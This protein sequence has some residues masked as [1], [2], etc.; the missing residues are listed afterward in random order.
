MKNLAILMLIYLIPKFSILSPLNV[1]NLFMIEQRW[2]LLEI[3]FQNKDNSSG[4]AVVQQV[5]YWLIR[6]TARVRASGQT[7]KQNTKS[8]SSAISSQQI[9]RK[10]SESKLKNCHEKF[11]KRFCVYW[12]RESPFQVCQYICMHIDI[13]KKVC[14]NRRGL[15]GSVLTYQAKSQGSRPWEDINTKYVKYF[16]GDFLSADYSQKL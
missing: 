15:V 14:R 11:L 8:I 2:D 3:Y 7:S 6:R 12:L 16:F 10:N 5:V 4:V 1:M 9:T 13:V